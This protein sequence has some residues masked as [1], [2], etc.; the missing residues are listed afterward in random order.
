[1]ADPKRGTVVVV[2]D[3]TELERLVGAARRD[4]S[5]LDATAAPEP[6][7]SETDHTVQIGDRDVAYR[8]RAGT[9]EVRLDDPDKPRGKMFYVA[10]TR[11]DAGD[12]ANRPIAFCFNGGPGSSSVWLHLGC[13]GPRRVAVDV[14]SVPKPGAV[15]ADNP[16]SILDVADLVFVDPIATGFSEADD[17]KGADYLGVKGDTESIA[18]FVRRF[19]TRHDRWSSPKFLIGESYGTTRAATIALHLA[20]RHG[21]YLDGLILISLALKFQTL[22]FEEGNDLPCVLYVPAYAATALHHGVLTADDPAAFV[23][24]AERWAVETYA[25]ALHRGAALPQADQ[26]RISLELS[27]FIGLPPD[28]I[29][30]CNNRVDLARF[31][32]GLLR[33]R[34]RVVGRLDSRFTE[35]APDAAGESLDTDPSFQALLG[36]YTS[37]LHRELK[38][39]LG[40]DNDDVYEILNMKAHLAWTWERDNRYLDV[41]GELRRALVGNPHLR[42]FVASGTYDLATPPSA[43]AYTLAQLGVGLND[44]RRGAIVHREYPAGHMMYVHGPSLRAMREHMAA[45]IA[46]A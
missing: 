35:I 24:E 22:M 37:A 40:Y 41:T 46:P 12:P 31:C 34:R 42:L 9:L 36:A 29:A 27:G 43:T 3:A 18:E 26:E 6:K 39:P 30:R 25:P 19:V 21:L 1:M 16:L 11:T 17:G 7:F 5:D 23:A 8:A 38:G 2:S 33:E 32:R 4:S 45:F 28:Y 10:Y 20:D 14:G 44:E 15:A 13:L